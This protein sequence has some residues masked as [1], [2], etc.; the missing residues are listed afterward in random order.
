M[1]QYDKIAEIYFKKR[2]EKNKFDWN[3]HI[4]HP[5]MLDILGNVKQ[6]II[7]DMGCGFGD[8]AKELLNHGAKKYI[9][10]DLSKELI[11]FANKQNISDATFYVGDMSKKLNH[12]NSSFDIVL[13]SLA[14][15]YIDNLKFLFK[16]VNRVLKNG[17]IFVFSTQHPIYNIISTSK[18][19][20][21]GVDK[22]ENEYKIYG[23]YFDETL[24]DYNMGK[25]LGF[26]KLHPYTSE[27]II[28]TIL[29]TGFEIIDYKDAKPIPKSKKYNSQDYKLTT[30]LPSFIL[31]KLKKK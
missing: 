17:G 7:L 10:F 20:M 6:K 27:T 18:T 2:Q 5:A 4:E 3:K 9:G 31:F 21:A 22:S 26:V 23:N 1:N 24:R 15:H 14:I 29:N 25:T 12:E 11:K 13:S 28:K 30:T 19:R 16:E 8:M